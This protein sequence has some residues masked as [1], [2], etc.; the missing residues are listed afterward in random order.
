MDRSIQPQRYSQASTHRGAAP[1]VL[2]ALEPHAYSEAIGKTVAHQRPALD[3]RIVKPKDLAAEMERRPPALVFSGKPR[4]D[5]C[6]EAVRWAEYRPYD[7]PDA[8]RV[9]GRLHEFPGLELEDL[10]GLVDR[11]AR[12]RR[13][14]DQV[15]RHSPR[16]V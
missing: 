8:V 10:L 15:I 9:D 11:L 4:P 14:A 2:F 7:D 12:Q 3:I 6:D 1:L 13:G 5:G 16:A